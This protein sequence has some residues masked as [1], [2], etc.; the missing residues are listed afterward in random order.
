MPKLGHFHVAVGIR[1][2]NHLSEG[3]Y[4]LAK[5]LGNHLGRNLLGHRKFLCT[6]LYVVLDS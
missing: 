3:G 5:K 4:D 2:W 6:E 1:G